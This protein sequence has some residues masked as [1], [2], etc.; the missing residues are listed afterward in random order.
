MMAEKNDRLW[1]LIDEIEDCLDCY[2][3]FCK[4]FENYPCEYKVK[5]RELYNRAPW[6]FPLR[7]EVKGFLGNGEVKCDGKVCK[8]VFVCIR[9][10]T[11]TFPSEAD[12]LFYGLLRDCGF[13]DAHVTDLIKCRGKAKETDAETIEKMAKNCLRFLEE[14]IKIIDPDLIVAV[15]GNKTLSEHL[16]KLPSRIKTGYMENQ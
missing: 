3:E 5:F 16:K 1:K 15:G 6:F 11:G 12:D 7:N 10:S 13:K 9:P 2:G 14:E 4:E 8:I